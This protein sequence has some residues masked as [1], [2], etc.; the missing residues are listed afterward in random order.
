M[1]LLLLLHASPFFWQ[2]YENTYNYINNNR[3]PHTSHPLGNIYNH[4]N[5]KYHRTHIT[6]C[7]MRV[8]IP[9][10]ESSNTHT[11]AFM[12]SSKNRG[13]QRNKLGKRS[14]INNNH[15]IHTARI[16]RTTNTIK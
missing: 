9:V 13:F 12:C 15:K 8:N 16:L 1:L 2:I 3:H 6:S 14:S 7:C 4:I 10:K 5:Y 11:D